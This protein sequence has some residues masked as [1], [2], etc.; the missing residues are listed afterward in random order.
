MCVRVRAQPE[1][2]KLL[3]AALHEARVISEGY[4]LL[5]RWLQMMN[6]LDYPPNYYNE[7]TWSKSWHK[8][9]KNKVQKMIALCFIPRSRN[10]VEV[11]EL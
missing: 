6:A 3:Y 11:K 4:R 1:Y 7:A 5:K 8:L 9:H 10:L 2:G